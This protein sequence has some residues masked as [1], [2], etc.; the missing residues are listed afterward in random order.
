MLQSFKK[1]AQFRNCAAHFVNIIAKYLEIA[2]KP[3]QYLEAKHNV[4]LNFSFAC[5]NCCVS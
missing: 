3:A 2:Y 4:A 1:F 5:I